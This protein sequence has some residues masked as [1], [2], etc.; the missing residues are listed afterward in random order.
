MP[1]NYFQPL[2]RYPAVEPLKG[3]FDKFRLLRRVSC[4]LHLLRTLASVAC[5]AA[6][7][8]ACFSVSAADADLVTPGAKSQA[9][10]VVRLKQFKVLKDDK[11]ET[12]FL[13]A[14]LVL[15]GDVLEYR[16]SYSNRSASA[17]AV[18]ATMPIPESTE[19]I[20]ESATSRSKAPHTVALKDAQFAKEPLLQRTTSASGATLSQPVGTLIHAGLNLIGCACNLDSIR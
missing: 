15:P 18:L 6:A 7:G 11:G 9:P 14:A 13:D 20:Q 3:E 5:L 4:S 1:H 12:Q 8:L 16:A 2:S 19:Y 10:I 17:V